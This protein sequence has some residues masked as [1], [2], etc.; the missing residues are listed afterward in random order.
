MDSET[1]TDNEVRVIKDATYSR[2][3]RVYLAKSETTLVALLGD[4]EAEV[5]AAATDAL[6]EAPGH[7]EWRSRMLSVRR[8][9][10]IDLGNE[11]REAVRLR[12]EIRS[13]KERY[14]ALGQA[15]L[16]EA[17]NRDWCDEYNE[18]ARDWDLPL[19]KTEFEVLVTLRVNA[20]NENAAIEYVSDALGIDK[21]GD[22]DVTYG[23]EY[24]VEALG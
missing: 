18:F 24:S 9:A 20:D 2:D 17:V 3:G 7:P 14:E 12:S 10:L 23:P 13:L 5:P 21:Y 16:E 6:L 19:T 8:K 4:D 15:L 22:P 11:R 1:Q